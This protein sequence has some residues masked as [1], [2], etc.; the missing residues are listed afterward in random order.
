MLDQIRHFLESDVFASN[1]IDG[2]RKGGKV[3]LSE[4]RDDL[5]FYNNRLYIQA[6]NELRLELVKTAHDAI[7]WQ[8]EDASLVDKILFLAQDGKRRT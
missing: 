2:L 1:T 8:T 7:H 6:G 3:G 5:L 4:L